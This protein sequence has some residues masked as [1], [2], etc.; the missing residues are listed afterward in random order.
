MRTR[1]GCRS[2][3]G[4]NRR[5]GL[6]HSRDIT[7]RRSYRSFVP[8]TSSRWVA[9]AVRA[10]GRS[11]VQI[12]KG[13]L[14]R[15]ELGRRVAIVEN[16]EE[17]RTGQED[18]K[19]NGPIPGHRA[20][21]IV[22]LHQWVGRCARP[23]F[24]NAAAVPAL[25][26]TSSSSS[27]SRNYRLVLWGFAFDPRSMLPIEPG[28]TRSLPAAARPAAAPT[29]GPW[30]PRPTRAFPPGAQDRTPAWRGLRRSF[31]NR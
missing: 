5:L 7:A 26:E 17:W 2:L 22:V 6:G 20:K 25:C 24:Q 3:S 1:F 15:R 8:R 28:L 21:I 23:P 30:L 31:F 12:L 29:M 11:G 16:G 19:R 27:F 9:S 10:G 14:P 4:S 13:M 18:L